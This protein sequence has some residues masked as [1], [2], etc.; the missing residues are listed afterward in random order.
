MAAHKIYGKAA[1]TMRDNRIY[2]I[3]LQ[4]ALEPGSTRTA[5]ALSAFPDI[6]ALYRA[7]RPS[8]MRAGFTGT[9][10]ERLSCKSLDP[11][12]RELDGILKQKGWVL[13]YEDR[14]YPETL[15]Q[16]YAPPVALY[17][18]GTFP[19]MDKLPAVTM[20]GT[21]KAT[22]YGMQVASAMAA[23]L[24]AGGCIVVSG[25]AVGIDAA[26]HTGALD[27][28]GITI[29]V[30]ACGLDVN[31]PR[32]NRFL[33]DRIVA[34]GGAVITEF[35]QGSQ[36]LKNHFAVRNRLLSGL[37][38]GVC[39]VESPQSGGSLITARHA[40]EQNRDVFVIP[41]DINSDKSQG[42]NDL[43]KGGA[44]LVTRPS[45][46]LRE[47]QLRFPHMLDL[48][49]ADAAQQAY[50]RDAVG[51]VAPPPPPD[52]R[53]PA[54]LR[55]A[56]HPPETAKKIVRFVPCP[57]TASPQAAALYRCLSGDPVHVE[58][59]SQQAGMPMG[60]VLAVL[61]E[62][63]LAGCAVSYAGARYSLRRMN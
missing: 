9:L 48:R 58:L 32:P 16:I 1:G 6:E 42:S 27:G 28:R 7:D 59:L 5:L 51:R 38:L 13:T 31:Y 52:K 55:Q 20:V 15:K 57:E 12:K 46:I 8:L 25:G 11:A 34:S 47:Y 26:C 22:P 53:P 17:G 2:W 45:E 33:R 14:A 21:R 60:Q 56:L 41:G 63:E 37:S 49:T 23:G 43:I 36:A 10:L 54:D 3:W 24:A 35:P 19:A 40:R 29:A 39:V 61:T 30:Q 18:K 4:L 50:S 62:L 44:M